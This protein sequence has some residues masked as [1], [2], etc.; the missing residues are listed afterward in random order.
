MKSVVVV[1]TTFYKSMEELRFR[2]ACDMVKAAVAAG[3]K[4]VIV[5]ASPIFHI[6]ETLRG[7]GA[8]VFPQL[9]KGMGPGR[10]EAF[11][12]AHEVAMKES[13]DFIMWTEPEK[14]DIIRWV[15]KMIDG[16]ENAE[17]VIPTR[18][19]KAWQSWPSFQKQSEGAANSVYNEVFGTTGFDPMFGP[20]IF[21]RSLCQEF[22]FCYC[23]PEIFGRDA[24]GASL[25]PDTYIQHYAPVLASLDRVRVCSVEVDMI[26]PPEQKVEEEGAANEAMLE[27]RKMQLGTLTTAYR[28]I[29]R[30]LKK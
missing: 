30:V 26:Y 18:S 24:T 27:K 14:V 8:T 11:F 1:T 7:L 3:H 21:D 19:E 28:A 12:H 20:V 9:H 25:V 6:A 29:A 4:V 22:A 10:R 17:I 5:D 16:L 23:D 2:L 13:I 15:E